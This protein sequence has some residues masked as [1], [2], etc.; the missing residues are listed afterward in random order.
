MY[1]IQEQS[2][3]NTHLQSSSAGDANGETREEVFHG[4]LNIHVNIGG[5]GLLALLGW[6]LGSVTLE[7]ILLIGLN[8]G[9][10]TV[11]KCGWLKWNVDKRTNL[12]RLGVNCFLLDNA[13][14][15]DVLYNEVNE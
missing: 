5:I 13:H 7:S 8:I 9:C 12:L 2:T 4:I 14:L 6:L 11:S 10:Q 3:K 1:E 15:I